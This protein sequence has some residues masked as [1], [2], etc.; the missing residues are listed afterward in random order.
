[1]PQTIFI[2]GSSTGLGRA[3]AL[4]F[5]SRG[6][7]VIATLRRPDE[8]TE[9]AATPGITVLP[10]DV[11]SVEQIESAVAEALRMGPVDVVF[12]NAGYGLG[13]PFEAASDEDITRQVHTNLMG[14]L[15]VTRAFIPAFRERRTGTFI[16]T[17]SIGG[18]ATFP[19]F[20]VYHATKWGLE[21]WSESLA[22]ELAPFGIRVKTVAPGGIKTDFSGRSLVFRSHDAYADL[23]A[24]V[25][26]TF[27]DPARAQQ[28]STAEQI[29]EVVFEAATDS[30]DRV[31]YVAGPDA[32]ALLAQR[33][34]L[35]VEA[36]RQQ[37]AR[38]FLGR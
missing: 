3:T 38:T 29:A 10:L 20:S 6:W 7:R 37:I 34:A 36:F 17:T 11:G 24:R 18:L 23:L 31:S 15:R 27:R 25:L 9:L 13:G 30:T 26:A 22:Y 12:N 4:L 19:F 5:A 2:T 28:Q 1:M 14:P 33:L 32:K 21:G 16:T 8:D 35:G